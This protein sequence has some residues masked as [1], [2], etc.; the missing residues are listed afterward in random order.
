LGTYYRCQYFLEYFKGYAVGA[1]YAVAKNIVATLAYY[2]TKAK[3]VT[4]EGSSLKDKRLW[5]DVTFTF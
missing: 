3:T 4:S 1:N 2:D 5:T